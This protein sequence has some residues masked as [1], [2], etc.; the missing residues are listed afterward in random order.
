VTELAAARRGE[1]SLEVRGVLLETWLLY[2]DLFRR[3][4]LVGLLVFAVLGVLD[5]TSANGEPNALLF[6]AALVLPVAGTALVQ[7]ALVNAVDDDRQKRPIRSAGV[8]LSDVRPRFGALLGVSVLTGL[9]VGFGLL[10][11]VV[12]GL[13]LFTRWSLSVPVVMLEGLSPRAAMR[14]SGELVRGRSWTIFGVLSSVAFPTILSAF[15]FRFALFTVFGRSHG[16]LAIWLSG[17]IASALTTPYAA[18][19]MSVV[20]YRLTAAESLS[21]DA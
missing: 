19:A 11:F 6:F 15:A 12:P 7:G 16:T 20:Y 13:V 18:H 17:T 1:P 5:A 21:R 3:S 9:G 14:R 8:L 2:R 10:F 4:L